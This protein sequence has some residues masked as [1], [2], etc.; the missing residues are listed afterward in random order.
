[1]IG[2]RIRQL[3]RGKTDS[4]VYDTGL[5]RENGE[6]ILAEIKKFSSKPIKVIFYSHH[7]T[8]HYNG[9]DALVSQEDVASGKV[10][11]YAWENFEEELASEFGATGP[12]Q[13]LRLGYY[14]GVFL[15][16]EDDHHHGCCGSASAVFSAHA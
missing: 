6:A 15:S 3:L 11:I 13:A 16:P 5:S 9:T 4:L 12:I 10:K 1:M 2:R 14:T 7:H 8:D